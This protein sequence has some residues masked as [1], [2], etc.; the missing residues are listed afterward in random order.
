MHDMS[1]PPAAAV[2]C[3]G[4]DVLVRLSRGR[5]FLFVVCDACARGLPENRVEGAERRLPHLVCVRVGGDAAL[6]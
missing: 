3:R 4:M 2:V 6:R 5:S 1:T